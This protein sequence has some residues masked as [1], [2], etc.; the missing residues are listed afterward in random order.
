MT[1]PTVTQTDTHRYIQT[2]R[3][4]K[5]VYI[6][7]CPSGLELVDAKYHSCRMTD[8]YQLVV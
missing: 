8:N 4:T 1:D 7:S 2:D 5:N 3:Q 6:F